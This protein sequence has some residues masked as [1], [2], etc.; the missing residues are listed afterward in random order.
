[1]RAARRRATAG[2]PASCMAP[3]ARARLGAGLRGA[4]R[5]EGEGACELAPA[6]VRTSPHEFARTLVTTCLCA[7][8]QSKT[9]GRHLFYTGATCATRSHALVSTLTAQRT[10]KAD[11][12][13]RTR[14][15]APRTARKDGRLAAWV[16]LRTRKCGLA[17]LSNH[18]SCRAQ[19]MRLAAARKT[20]HGTGHRELSASMPGR[21]VRRSAG[22]HAPR[23]PA[24]AKASATRPDRT[25]PRSSVPSVATLRRSACAG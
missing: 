19:R 24:V 1:M 22:R 15:V 12:S 3:H 16:H 5:R 4:T 10:T 13:A 7:W 14:S 11:A 21:G 6:A 25:T 8:T 17:S 23:G 20:T 9:D 2:A 18:L